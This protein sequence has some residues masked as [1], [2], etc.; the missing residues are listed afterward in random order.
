M[1]FTLAHPAAAIPLRRLLGSYAVPSAL[2]IGCLAPDLSYFLSIQIPRGTTHSPTALFWFCLPVG[3]AVYVAFHVFVKRPLVSLLPFY[4]RRRLLPL[5]E[6]CDSL[7]AA[8][9]AGVLLSLLAG[10]TTHILW[11]DCT[12]SGVPLVRMLG[13]LAQPQGAAGG[14]AGFGE[15]T[16]QL[17]S[18]GLGFLALGVFSVRWLLRATPSATDRRFAITP[19]VRAAV[20]TLLLLAWVLFALPSAVALLRHGLTPHG[21]EEFLAHAVIVGS[22]ASACALILFGA[23]WQV[24]EE[25]P[26]AR[27]PGSATQER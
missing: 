11:D 21:L 14:P 8:P 17:L 9:Q 26:S 20:L 27:A 15:N 23:F 18:T 25:E 6:P 3:L 13:A 5:A 12:H 19:R 16:L 24:T 4:L 7:P 10:A 1:P 22:T 2:V